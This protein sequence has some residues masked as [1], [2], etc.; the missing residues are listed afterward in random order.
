M[1]DTRLFTELSKDEKDVLLDELKTLK[2]S[3]SPAGMTVDE[4]EKLI[5]ATKN[6]LTSGDT[7][8]TNSNVGLMN[9]DIASTTQT[10]KISDIVPLQDEVKTENFEND[11][12]QAVIPEDETKTRAKSKKKTGLGNFDG[13]CIT[14][15]A[16]VFDKKCSG[17]GRVF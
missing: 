15:G 10:T 4:I 3:C 13:I 12:L 16:K 7:K 5:A 9:K 8:E 17:C 14:C 11:E 2:L 6:N 1:T